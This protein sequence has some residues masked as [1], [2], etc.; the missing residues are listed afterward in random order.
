MTNLFKDGLIKLP[1]KVTWFPGHM[2]RGMRLL[3]ENLNKIDIFVEGKFKDLIF[4]SERC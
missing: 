4:V 3:T 2:F 1:E